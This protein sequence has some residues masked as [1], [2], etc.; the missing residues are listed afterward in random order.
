MYPIEIDGKM[1][2]AWR[3]QARVYFPP[4]TFRRIRY[5]DFGTPDRVVATTHGNTSYY[6]EILL[7]THKLTCW[8]D[9]QIAEDD[10]AAIEIPAKTLRRKSGEIV[11]TNI[12]RNELNA[13]ETEFIQRERLI[14]AQHEVAIALAASR[15]RR[16]S[17]RKTPPQKLS[18]PEVNETMLWHVQMKILDELDLKLKTA[19]SASQV[20]I[21]YC[22]DH[23]TLMDMH[24][25]NGW[26]YRTLK[27]R[28][29]ALE[30]FLRKKFNL[31]L[32]SFYLDRAI[33]NAA[34]KQL[35]DERA[36]HISPRALGD[37]S[38]DSEER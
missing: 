35:R 27:L 9:C 5:M 3:C 12:V 32:A 18:P 2:S 19:P 11:P 7:T 14:E 26:P 36:K 25:Q 28:K 33:F 38:S 15:K 31:R 24:R 6:I 16:S 37:F 17:P 23:L 34:E 21:R 8:T 22:R 29:A 4:V 20:F 1:E 10:I 30:T 13:E